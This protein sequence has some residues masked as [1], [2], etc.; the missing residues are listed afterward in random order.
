MHVGLCFLT[1]EDVR[2]GTEALAGKLRAGD[3]GSTCGALTGK[4]RAGDNGGFLS[5]LSTLP[6]LRT[7]LDSPGS[8]CG[9]ETVPVMGGV[10]L[11][12]GTQLS[13]GK[14]VNC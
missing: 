1:L 3:N 12:V 4:L 11:D 14:T 9:M 10:S 13:S 5:G 8:V 7:T 6:S 2:G